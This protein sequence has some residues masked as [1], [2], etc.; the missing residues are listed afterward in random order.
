MF[1]M[2]ALRNDTQM[3]SIRE[4]ENQVVVGSIMGSGYTLWKVTMKPTIDITDY[5]GKSNRKKILNKNLK[6]TISLYNES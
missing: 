4:K 2:E 3:G 5:L 6:I 1:D